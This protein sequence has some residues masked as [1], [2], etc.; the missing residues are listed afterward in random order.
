MRNLSVQEPRRA[1]GALDLA[2]EPLRSQRRL[3]KSM[4]AIV[5][6]SFV[7]HPAQADNL[8][9]LNSEG[10]ALSVI[11]DF[12][13]G[14]GRHPA[15]VLAPGQGYHMA[16]PAMEATARALTEQG[17]AVF[18]FDWTY[19]TQQP[20][21]QPSDDLSSELRDLRAVLAAARRH[22]KVLGDRLFVGGK[23]LGSAVA[24]R[25][26]AADAALLGAVLLTPICSRLPKGE[27]LPRSVAI[28]NYP[29]LELEQRPTL[30]ISGEK[31]PLCA[32]RFL[33]EFAG[34]SM[35]PVRIA[36]VGGDHSFESPALPA[37]AATTA[38][39]R[40]IHAASTVSATFVADVSNATP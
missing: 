17:I 40:N 25:A 7:A 5:L 1:F 35:G 21:G 2:T 16:L 29:G 34:K 19:F 28:E 13:S 6:S 27:T 22:P 26:F 23:S 3:L 38:R 10:I 37:A 30:W 14:E 39:Q 9:V 12:P 31:D 36:I 18:R 33:Y 4:L 15:I 24:W 20:K 8:A 11:A 32:P